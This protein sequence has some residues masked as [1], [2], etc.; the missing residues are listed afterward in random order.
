MSY[1]IIIHWLLTNQLG[2]STL[3]VLHTFSFCLTAFVE[4]VHIRLR[5]PKSYPKN[6]GMLKRDVCPCCH[7]CNS[8]K[9]LRCLAV[10]FHK[11]TMMFTA[12]KH[13][14]TNNSSLSSSNTVDSLQRISTWTGSIVSMPKQ[15]QKGT[16]NN[17]KLVLY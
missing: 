13:S 17:K 7:I 5:P 11:K 8:I 9:A 2:N 6:F 16:F 12:M 3:S 4:L 14:K 15:F 10:S 1:K